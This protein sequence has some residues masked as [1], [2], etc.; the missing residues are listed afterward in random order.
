MSNTETRFSDAPIGYSAI[1]PSPYLSAPAQKSV[2]WDTRTPIT[3]LKDDRPDSRYGSHGSIDTIL[4]KQWI[5]NKTETL[6][7][8]AND[9]YGQSSF[10]G[11]NR[12]LVE[13]PRESTSYTFLDTQATQAIQPRPESALR[14][15]PERRYTTQTADHQKSPVVQG[16]DS[17]SRHFEKRRRSPHNSLSP[18]RRQQTKSTTP[19]SPNSNRRNVESSRSHR[20]RLN[21]EVQPRQSWEYS[22][23]QKPARSNQARSYQNQTGTQQVPYTIIPQRQ[24]H[25][26]A[27]QL[28]TLQAAED[29]VER[30]PRQTC[31]PFRPV[32]QTTT[33]STRQRS[34]SKSPPPL[35]TEYGKPTLVYTPR[36]PNDSS[37]IE[38]D[39]YGR[40]R[41]EQVRTSRSRER[42]SSLAERSRSPSPW[43]WERPQSPN[44]RMGNRSA[45]SNEIFRLYQTRDCLGNVL[46][47]LDPAVARAQYNQIHRA[48]MRPK[49]HW[50]LPARKE[51]PV[52]QHS[53]Q[54]IS[55]RSS[56]NL[57]DAKFDE[58]NN[59]R[60]VADGAKLH[61][62]QEG[63]V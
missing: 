35:A 1:S 12:S 26:S 50:N 27:S 61:I 23:I 53:Y 30:P 46:Y 59:V 11:S 15:E 5:E 33:Y 32:A 7:P 41:E 4:R 16:G 47:E 2:Q 57:E 21:E 49:A 54:T 9:L 37:F 17:R 31:V 40:L 42:K 20:S 14:K 56:R 43:E 29:Y 28:P 52:S 55:N 22:S 25:R 38:D 19:R 44:Y 62:V 45:S 60:L 10:R 51:R 3:I 24:R 58:Y 34:R 48:Q 18:A 39:Y 8:N 36:N 63:K 6:S 13:Q